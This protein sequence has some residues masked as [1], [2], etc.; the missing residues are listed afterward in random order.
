MAQLQKDENSYFFEGWYTFVLP[1]KK[2]QLKNFSF[3]IFIIC[4]KEINGTPKKHTGYG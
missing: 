3:F 2:K 4:E 1:T